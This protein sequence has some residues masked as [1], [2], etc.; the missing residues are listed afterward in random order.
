MDYT[1]ILRENGMKKY[2]PG[3]TTTKDGQAKMLSAVADTIDVIVPFNMNAEMSIWNNDI[4]NEEEFKRMVG[5]VAYKVNELLGM[6]NEQPLKE[7]LV[8]ANSLNLIQTWIVLDFYCYILKSE[9]TVNIL[10]VQ[11]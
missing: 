4:S 6:A 8:S 9:Y 5:S 1:Q 7:K 11:N 2:L 10:N 3:D